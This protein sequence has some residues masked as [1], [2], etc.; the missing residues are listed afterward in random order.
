MK[1][2]PLYDGTLVTCLHADRNN[3]SFSTNLKESLRGVDLVQE[4]AP[5]QVDLKLFKDISNPVVPASG[6]GLGN[7]IRRTLISL[8]GHS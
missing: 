7:Q 8:A 4:N 6:Y 1:F 5:E 2:E 3:L